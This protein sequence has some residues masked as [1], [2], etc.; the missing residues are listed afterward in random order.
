MTLRLLV[1]LDEAYLPHL[2]VMLFS[3]LSSDGENDFEVALQ[4]WL[5][6]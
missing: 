2:N 4:V 3:V 6:F 5:Q 1:T